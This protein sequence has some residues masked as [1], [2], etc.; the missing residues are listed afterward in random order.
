MR[1]FYF[2]A[3]AAIMALMVSCNNENQT[4]ET[5]AQ[6]T[7]E[8]PAREQVSPEVQ[9]LSLGHNLAV[10]GYKNESAEALVEAASILA[11]VYTNV[12]EATVIVKDKNNQ[13]IESEYVEDGHSFAPADLI[14]AAKRIAGADEFLL[15]MIARVEQQIVAAQAAA[16]RGSVVGVRTL[17][18]TI[19]AGNYNEYEIEFEGGQF[20]EIGVEGDGS[21]DLDLYICDE[22]MNLLAEDVDYGDHCYCN[23][24]PANTGKYVIRIYNRGDKKNSYYLHIN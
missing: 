4:T 10:Y 11:T 6:T 14:Q 24:V 7:D 18:K 16:R 15:T 12:L 2:L 8:K 1:K 13:P 21:T 19:G 5:T 22:D 9:T 20:A 17:E 23:W 3:V